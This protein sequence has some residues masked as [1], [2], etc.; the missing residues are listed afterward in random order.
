MRKN[1]WRLGLRPQTPLR[2]LT[3]L[4]RPLAGLGGRFA[5]GNAAMRQ[6]E[7]GFN[8]STVMAS[9]IDYVH[10]LLHLHIPLHLR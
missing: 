10:R 9:Y 3:T 7:V 4:P 2:E 5:K 6:K 8:L 1:R